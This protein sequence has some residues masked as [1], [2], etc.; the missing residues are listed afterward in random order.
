MS[1]TT[2]NT[3]RLAQRDQQIRQAEELLGSLPQRTGVAK[4]LF[5]GRFVADWVFPYPRLSGDQQRDVDTAVAGLEQFCD[6]HLDPARIDREADIPRET[7][8]GLAQLGLLGMTAPTAFGGRGF[9]Q[10]GYC[11]L[12]EVIGARCSS[13]S[14][15]VNAHHSIGMRGLLLFGTEEQKQKWLPDL[16]SGRKLAAFALT[17]PAAGS[18]ASNVQTAA[19]PSADGSHFV[20]NG[21]KRYITN[22]AIADVLTVMARTPIE[23]SNETAITAFLVTPDMPGFQVPEPRMEKLGIRG[24]AT[25]RLAFDNLHVPRENMLGPRGKGLKIA[26]TVLNFGRTTFGACCTGAA[27]TCLRLATEHAHSRRQFGR[28][29]GEFEL[30]QQKL[31]HMAAWTYGME[32]MTTVTA[33]LID[34][35]LEDYM[36]ETAMLKVWSTE[37]LWT[38]VNDAFQIHGGAAYFTDLPLERMLRDHRINQI[39]E[40]ANEVLLS[41]IAL[42]GMRGPGLRMK[43]VADSLWRPWSGMGSIGR[44]AADSLR[45]R[46]STPLVPVRSGELQPL[47]RRLAKLVCRLGATVQRTLIRHREEVLE[48]QLVQERLSWTAM[49]LLA[50]AC[51]LSRWDD[52]LIRGDRTHDAVARLFVADSLRHAEACLRGMQVNDDQLVLAAAEEHVSA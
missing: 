12:L 24:T 9:S 2:D 50:T 34:R 38:I 13:T 30:V 7:I 5:E 39:G 18:D 51:T 26:L 14:I 19:T 6:E 27:K 20:L 33:G 35:G 42:T 11:R 44:F 8:D 17:E 10:M 36:L 47:A 32:A 48:R 45:I 37:R 41:F 25:A 16:V 21:E 28:T 4:G 46:F 1:T 31:A 52:E 22:G 49:E 23:G 40:G 43:E 15:F 29:L 3:D